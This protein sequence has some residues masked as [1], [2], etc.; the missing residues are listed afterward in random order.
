MHVVIAGQMPPPIG[1]QNIN[2]KRVHDLLQT[3]DRLLVS[4]LKFE[5]TKSWGRARKLNGDKVVELIK[6]IFRMF[7]IRLN[8]EI[9]FMLFPAGG[10][11]TIPI[12]R[13]WLL[14]PFAYLVSKRVAIH[15]R[16]AGL[17][18]RLKISPK[19]F[20][21]ITRFVYKHFT[22][23]AVVLADYGKRD[24]ESVGIKNIVV[25]PNAYEDKALQHV[26]REQVDQATFLSVGHLC[27]DKGTP[28]LIA[29][30]GRFAAKNESV[31]LE[32]VG[33]TLAPYSE[34]QLFRDIEKTGASDRIKWRGI[35]RGQDLESAYRE[36]SLFVFASV[37][38]Y[39]SF[40][41]VLIEAM[42]WSLPV[43]VTD[44]RANVSV[45]GE[46]FGGLV[47]KN[48]EKDL[49]TE[50]EKTLKLAYDLRDEWHDWGRKN[51]VIYEQ[52]Y[53]LEKLKNNLCDL[54]KVN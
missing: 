50:L 15:F 28:E 13:D 11:H 48:P 51:R 21:W 30:F 9:D 10:P 52:Q 54:I 37:A 44:W 29:A 5:F 34:E 19:W 46:G 45:C 36:A 35:L 41:M 4:H 43:I 39:E 49:A 2:I 6:V 40:G 22:T 8:G 7:K 25:L 18:D 16:A 32:L 53:T 3:D 24:A 17:D 38:P 27:S 23:E 31:Y 26:E 33:E 42:Q 12:L 47:V 1:G 20:Q 14:L